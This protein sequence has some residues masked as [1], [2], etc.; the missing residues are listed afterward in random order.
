MTEYEARIGSVVDDVVA[1]RA[2][3]GATSSTLIFGLLAVLLSKS[4]I[5]E[6]DLEV[7]F[8]VEN[9]NAKN[10]LKS[11]F[12]SKYGESDFPIQNEGEL[13]DAH[14]IYIKRIDKIKEA[15]VGA[16]NELKPQ[17]SKLKK[18]EKPKTLITEAAKKPRKSNKPKEVK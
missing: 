6:K 11:L 1:I 12:E 3:G 14:E 16:A 9:E 15:V 10:T 7:V 4:K 2:N 13:K 5:A 17:K 8:S 18:L